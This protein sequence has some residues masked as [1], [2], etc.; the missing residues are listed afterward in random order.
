MKYIALLRGINVGGKNKVPMR[1]L[2]TCFE[3][4]GFENV[5]T[6]I[7]SGNVLFDTA[8]PDT[9]AIAALCEKIVEQWFGFPVRTAVISAEELK[10]TLENAPEWWGM[11]PDVKH[12]ALFCLAPYSSAEIMAEVGVTKPE[13]E[14]VAAYGSVIFW[15]APVKT[16]SQTR[17][18]KIVGTKVYRHVTIR[19]ANTAMRL[20]EL[21]G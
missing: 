16:F 15:S 3:Q 20:L 9:D 1:D 2:K 12:N 4:A 17:W 13:Y 11:V 10:D 7:N 14:Q 19:N 21:S 6:Y 8:Q 5:S 18:S